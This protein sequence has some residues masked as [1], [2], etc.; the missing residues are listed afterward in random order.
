MFNTKNKIV[1]YK[2]L[3]ACLLLI[4]HSGYSCSMFKITENGRTIV[5]NNEDWVSPNSE[6]WFE[7][8]NELQ[9]G[10]AYVGFINRFPQGAMNE[11]GLVFDGF[12]TDFYPVKNT[13]GKTQKSAEE[14][15]QYTMRNLSSVHQVKDYLSKIDL[16][17]LSSSVLM[18]V[19]KSGEYLLVEG[20]ILILGKEAYYVQS[21]FI[22]S[23]NTVEEDKRKLEYF[24]NG[25]E[26]LKRSKPKG[27]ED[28]CTLVME[29]M[30]HRDTQYTSIYDLDKG[31]IKLYN[32]H[33]YS[34]DVEFNL[35]AELKKGA[36]SYAIPELFPESTEGVIRYRKYND[37]NNP[38]IYLKEIWEKG[39]KGKS[40]EEIEEF[41][42]ESGLA[43]LINYVG[44][45][46]LRDKKEVAG[47]IEIFKYG[48]EIYPSDANL[49]DSLGE[50]YWIAKE[51]DSAI[52]SYGKS[53][54]LN[55]KNL[56]AV[57]MLVKIKKA[58]EEKS[59][60]S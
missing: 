34:N 27:S 41:K 26:L 8:G 46:W 35:K 36:H 38:T 5:G 10:V 19:D 2:A 28:Y 53:L 14:V 18:F 12:A 60:K 58:I 22:P 44:Y 37:V 59:N 57:D 39:I 45:E 54:S 43:W 33:N 30:Q 40:K 55:P 24:Q 48:T 15:I 23:K 3:L 49:Y 20:D 21:N 1:K 56:N 25:V 32:Y 51:F 16:S 47:A 9:H 52:A 7:P 50:S 13:E 11:A 29:K 6:I 17:F 42:S 4:C 31:T